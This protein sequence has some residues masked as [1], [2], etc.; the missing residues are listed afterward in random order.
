M[1]INSTKRKF[2]KKIGL[3]SSFLALNNFFIFK[4]LKSKNKVKPKVVI[5]GYGIGGAT[6]LEYLM[7]YTDLMDIIIIE[8]NKKTQTCPMSNLVLSEIM[9]YKSIVHEFNHKRLK[10]IKF[11]NSSVEGINPHKKSLSINGG[12]ELFYDFLIL[13]PGVG[14]KN[15]IEGY[16]YEDKEIV[17]HCWDGSK[18]LLEFK[19]RLND[20]EDKSTIIIS[21]PDY[22]YRCPPAPY[23]RACLLAN[24][25]QRKKKKN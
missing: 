14:F 10:D 9:T 19:K 11:I 2:L 21:A 17:P 7:N 23:E 6:C 22:P 12:V 15:D 3:Y 18:N 1:V 16:D 4:N 8:K 5:I 24:F 25:M 13:S 20:L